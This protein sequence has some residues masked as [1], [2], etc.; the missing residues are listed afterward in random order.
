MKG[1]K[2]INANC[3]EGWLVWCK[4][5]LRKV[6]H[7]LLEN[8]RLMATAT[9]TATNTFRQDSS[10]S[11]ASLDY[12]KSFAQKTQNVLS[13][14]VTRDKVKVLYQKVGHVIILWKDDLIF[15]VKRRLG[16]SKSS[17]D[18]QQAINQYWI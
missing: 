1:S 9:A 3:C 17:F 2:A 18:T 15:T 14:R 4:T 8:W 12:P 7:L 5:V 13:T 16:R 11:R 10:H 6:S